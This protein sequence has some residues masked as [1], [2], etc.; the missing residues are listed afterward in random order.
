MTDIFIQSKYDAD[1][2]AGMILR[3]V[4]KEGNGMTKTVGINFDLHEV[5]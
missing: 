2:V 3:V 5:K 1:L 4:Y